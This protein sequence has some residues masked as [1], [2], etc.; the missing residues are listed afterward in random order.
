MALLP[1]SPTV[2]RLKKDEGRASI[3]SQ[4]AAL[5]RAVARASSRISAVP[6]SIFRS[7]KATPV[8]NMVRAS[9]DQH[10]Q[11]PRGQDLAHKYA[12]QYGRS[13]H[14][15]AGQ[16]SRPPPGAA[17]RHVTRL[18]TMPS[19]SP[20]ANHCLRSGNGSIEEMGRRSQ[21]GGA[22][23]VDGHR[24]LRLWVKHYVTP[25]CPWQQGDGR[26]V[27]S[28]GRPASPRC[29]STTTAGGVAGQCCGLGPPK[30]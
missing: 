28:R 12:Q 4:T 1:R 15:Q 30:R 5:I 23:G 13:Q 8:S 6:L 21:G 3:R 19:S 11:V 27:I 18:K 14:G 2:N 24:A 9:I 17:S 22:P 7:A 20:I 16:D 29:R 10:L 26:V 25:Q